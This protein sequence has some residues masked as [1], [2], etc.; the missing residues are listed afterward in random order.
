MGMRG[1]RRQPAVLGCLFFALHDATRGARAD[2]SR[3]GKQRTSCVRRG[4]F[5]PGCR[6][7]V[8]FLDVSCGSA[9]W[10]EFSSRPSVAVD[11]GGL[12]TE[13]TSLNAHPPAKRVSQLKVPVRSLPGNG[14][15]S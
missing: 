15:A 13:R 9:T 1:A 7:G 4:G 2:I 10:G 14:I 8:A 3:L 5:K 11:P 12:G 6:H